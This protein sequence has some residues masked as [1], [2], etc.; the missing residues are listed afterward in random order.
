ML[1]SPACKS[2]SLT[3]SRKLLG[4]SANWRLNVRLWQIHLQMQPDSTHSARALIK[5]SATFTPNWPKWNQTRQSQ[6]Q[7]VSL[8]VLAFLPNDSNSRPRRSLEVGV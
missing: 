2:T 5:H 1:L 8:L 3:V 6:E 7:P 4:S